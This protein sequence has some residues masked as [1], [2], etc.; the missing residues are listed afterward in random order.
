VRVL[1]SLGAKFAGPGIGTTAYH[2]VK[3]LYEQ[4]MLQQVLCGSFLPSDIPPSRIKALGLPSRGLRKLAT[5]DP[6][7]V[8]SYLHSV[9]YDLW[10]SRYVKEAD[11]LHVWG[12]DGLLSLRRAKERGMITVVQ[13]ASTHPRYQAELF[14]EEY[15]RWGVR[16]RLPEANLQRADAEVALA[17]YVLIPSDF[18][19]QTFLERGVDERKLLLLPFGVDVERFHPLSDLDQTE[20]PFRV[21]FVG[22]ISIRKGIPYL[23]EA[24]RLLRWGDAELWLL[25]RMVVNFPRRLLQLPGVRIFS[26]VPDPVPFYQKADLFAF[27]SLEEGSALVTYEAL[28]CGLPVV[29][30]PQAGSVVRDGQEG[31]IVPI[32]D[33]IALAERLDALRRDRELRQRMASRARQRALEFTWVRHGEQLAS[34]Y[35]SLG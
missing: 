7:G 29:T 10:A 1:Y 27:P 12:N 22:Q 5:F 6:S 8:L 24:W 3:G 15:A 19:R 16:F 23:L 14:R 17:D 26:F 2:G 9:F 30:T 21:L 20:R 4:G 11:L 13:R 35:A 28:A 25:G 32:R 34:L 33:S 31:F 18:V